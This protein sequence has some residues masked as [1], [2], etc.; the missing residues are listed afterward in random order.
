MYFYIYL[1]FYIKFSWQANFSSDDKTHGILGYLR[2]FALAQHCNVGILIC[3]SSKFSSF[4]LLQFNNSHLLLEEIKSA[5][6]WRRACLQRSRTEIVGE[7]IYMRCDNT[8]CV[9]I[10][11]DNTHKES[12]PRAA[13]VLSHNDATA[14]GAQSCSGRWSRGRWNIA[15]I[16]LDGISAASCWLLAPVWGLIKC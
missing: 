11:Q 8:C 14:S 2:P 3:V 12:K 16:N 15:N 13:A 7:G 5:H 4:D 10:K 9:D 1:T 6:R